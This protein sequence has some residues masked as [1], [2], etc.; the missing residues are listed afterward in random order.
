MTDWESRYWSLVI[1]EAPPSGL[2][3][4][5]LTDMQVPLDADGNYTIVISREEDR[6]ANA[7]EDNGVTWMEWS[8][9]GEGLDDPSNRAD[10]GM[11]VFRYHVQRP[12]VGAQPGEDHRAGHRGRC[13]GAVLPARRVHG[14]GDLRGERTEEMNDAEI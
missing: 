8:P 2:S 10:F 12:D 4:D 5:G 6:P 14:Q 3:N 9:R 13:D 7:T 11:L 1:C